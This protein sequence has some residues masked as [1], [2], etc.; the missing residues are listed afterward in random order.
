MN[1]RI[2]D[3]L[4]R[5]DAGSAG[6]IDIAAFGEPRMDGKA[7]Y[8][9]GLGREITSDKDLKEKMAGKYALAWGLSREDKKVQDAATNFTTNGLNLV[10]G[11]S[12]DITRNTDD[13]Y[14]FVPMTGRPLAL[15]S[16]NKL[17]PGYETNSYDIR[18]RSG[19]ADF[20]NPS[21][22]FRQLQDANYSKERK[23]QGAEWYASTF[24]TSLPDQ[25]TADVLGEDD[26][27][28]KQSAATEALDGMRERLSGLGDVGKKIPGFMRLGDALYMLGGTA[29][30]VG[31]V[32]ALTMMIKLAAMEMQ[33]RN[34]NDGKR[35][36][37]LL[38][39]EADLYA[40]QNAFFGTD[41]VGES[42]WDRAG[43][44]YPWLKNA[45]WSNRMST[46]S[47]ANLTRWVLYTDDPKTTY[48]EHTET[49]LFG[50]YTEMMV[51]RFLLLRRHGGVVSKIPER[52][53]Y[54]DFAAS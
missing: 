21:A 3:L 43:R 47:T 38:A 45:I 6:A 25:W 29:F 17:K 44:Y 16:F 48:I 35:P 36:T 7:L 46:A 53:M 34:S 41:A 4:N 1:V 54:I 8:I 2:N 19:N 37:R 24:S 23:T 50:P 40:M 49:M 20:V 15:P 5:F 14:I 22:G 26:M 10:G 13:E 30:S 32:T 39:P 52:V 12:E 31:T 51:Q 11:R 9:P 27:G 28:E 18:T 42:V 33:Y